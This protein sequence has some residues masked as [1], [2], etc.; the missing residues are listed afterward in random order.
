MKKIIYIII[1]AIT[2]TFKAQAQNDN[3]SIGTTSPDASAKLDI[4]STT[5]GLLPPRMTTAQRDA[6]ATPADGLVIFNLDDD[7]LN[8]YRAMTDGGK[9][10]NLCLGRIT[11]GV[12][13]DVN[14]GQIDI[15][16]SYK[17]GTPFNQQT[18][19]I[20]VPIYIV[21]PGTFTALSNTVN[22]VVFSANPTFLNTGLQLI[23]M[24][25]ISDA[26]A[27]TASGI[28]TFSVT[29]AETEGAGGQSVCNSVD[30]PFKNPA[31][32]VYT[33]INL[34]GDSGYNGNIGSSPLGGN[35]APDVRNWI[36]ANAAGLA[37]VGNVQII[38]MDVSGSTGPFI[39]KS[40]LNQGDVS[41]VW[42]A[43]RT[44]GYV[45][46]T[47]RIVKEWQDREGGAI[48]AFSDSDASAAGFVTEL[49]YIPNGADSA[50]WYLS[51]NFPE[52]FD[53]SI[54][55]I[56]ISAGDEVFATGAN[57]GAMIGDGDPVT[58]TAGGQQRALIDTN[59][60]NFM[61]GD[62][63]TLDVG[64]SQADRNEAFLIYMLKYAIQNTPF[65]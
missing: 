56:S 20:L 33:I 34:E 36:L 62:K 15:L 59:K 58:I 22:G 39:L 6:I 13:E 52:I 49:D 38:N 48:F 45:G 30:V 37:D 53:N 17:V 65:K 25:P 40:R 18:V 63:G 57:Y 1:V 16:G 14:C 31:D 42:A 28:A 2:F 10:D 21:K 51:S 46:G 43:A 44:N 4:V 8:Q 12:A 5:Q 64:T 47:G 19:K 9:W 3:V 61:I 35:V 60:L 23:E 50:N 41:I 26:T 29:I 24:G 11:T 27:G 54:G 55:G 32:A 7:C